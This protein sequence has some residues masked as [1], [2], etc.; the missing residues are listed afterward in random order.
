MYY[1]PPMLLDVFRLTRP[2][3]AETKDSVV[4]YLKRDGGG[5]NYDRAAAHI[6]S[7]YDGY[8][9]FRSLVKQC[10]G[11]GDSTALVQNAAVVEL[12]APLSVGRQMQTFYLPR[13]ELKLKHGV[14]CPL[15]PRF[16]FTEQKTIKVFYLHPRK[17]FRAQLSDLAA[18]A[19]TFKT[20][21]LEDDFYGQPA[22]VEIVD[23]DRTKKKAEK[24]SLSDLGPLLK[25]DPRE[26]MDR[27]VEAFVAIDESRAAGEK[28]PRRQPSRDDGASPRFDF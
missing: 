9:N 2:T 10:R 13:R 27:F 21:I 26:T 4:S 28:K 20:H 11:R 3:L 15:G 23:V 16:F 5:F 19:C 17:D 8:R 25:E 12:A 6:R 7:A 24:Y 1:D 22:D 18:L 14:V